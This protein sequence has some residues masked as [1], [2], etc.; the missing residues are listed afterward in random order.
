MKWPHALLTDSGGYQVFSLAKQRT[1]DDDGITFRSHLDGT[2]HRLTPEEAM[3]VQALLGSDVAMVLDECPPGSSSR[4]VVRRAIERTTAWA[5]RCLQI[6]P[7]EGQARFGIVQ[8]GTELDLRRSH[9]QTIAALGF[10]GI[11]LG[12]FS[13]GEP[14]EQMYEI[15]AEIGPAMPE[16]RPRYL[17]GV[18]TPTD[19]LR[20]LSSGIDLF[21]CVLP[22]RNARNGQALTWGGRVNLR[23]SR[24]QHDDGSLD[25]RCGC[26]VCNTYSRA[27]L[28][29]LFKA[30]EM[31]GPRLLSLHNL[32]FYGALMRKA[33]E[34]IRVGKLGS[35]V[36]ATVAQMRELDEVNGLDG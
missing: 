27:Y 1:I 24:H 10:D 28:R 11:A 18:G 32:H 15:L 4:D 36:E 13:V 5:K 35:W 17:M 34:M 21:D 19:L 30:E 9:L 2:L 6:D 12:G 8:G 25:A 14:Q 20:A 16:D 31:L 33:R 29:H 7:A 3:R 26:P 22:T 23:Q